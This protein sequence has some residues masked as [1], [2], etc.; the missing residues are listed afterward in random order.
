M[1]AERPTNSI[2]IVEADFCWWNCKLFS[3]V[4]FPLIDRQKKKKKIVSRGGAEESN[5]HPN[6][7]RPNQP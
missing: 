1:Y 3:S 5:F 7:R 6:S 2:E 4:N